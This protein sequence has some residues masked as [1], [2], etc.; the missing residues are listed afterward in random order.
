MIAFASA[1][2]LMQCRS[3]HSLSLAVVPNR[4]L[5]PVQG[6]GKTVEVLA[7]IL[8]NPAHHS[9]VSGSNDRESGLV[10]S[11]DTLVV[12]AVSLVGQVG[13]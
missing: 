9:V 1:A 7:L 3:T 8:S 4:V 13:S 12:C 5:T 2:A 10:V 6:L 11:R